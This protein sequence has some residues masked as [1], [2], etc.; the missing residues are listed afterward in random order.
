[1]RHGAGPVPATLEAGRV[2]GDLAG[3]LRHVELGPGRIVEDD[4]QE[5]PERVVPGRDGPLVPLDRI[6]MC[7]RNPLGRETQRILGP[8]R[9]EPLPGPRRDRGPAPLAVGDPVDRFRTAHLQGEGRRHAGKTA[10][11]QSVVGRHRDALPGDRCE[12]VQDRKSVV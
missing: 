9:A 10:G 6:D 11:P 1:M 4:L 7:A 8:Q 3:D 12:S 2:E 5:R